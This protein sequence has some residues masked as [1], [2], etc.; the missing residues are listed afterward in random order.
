MGFD[1]GLLAFT[2][3]VLGGIGD[4]TGAMLG[5]YV[6]GFINAFS[7]QYLSS[8]WTRAL[9]FTVLILVLVFKPSGLL[10]KSQPEKF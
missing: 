4:V 10:G 2:S 8:E 3:A 7:D 6:I 1:A 5:G 9:V